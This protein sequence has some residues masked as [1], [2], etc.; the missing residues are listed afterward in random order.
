MLLADS[1]SKNNIDSEGSLLDEQIEAQIGMFNSYTPLSDVKLRNLK[2]ETYDDSELSL[3]KEYT[4]KGWSNY[5][6]IDFKI[7]TILIH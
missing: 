6:Y 5:S 1:L 2:S 3:L 7:K 4:V